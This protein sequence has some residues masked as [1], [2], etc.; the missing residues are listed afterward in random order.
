MASALS[1]CNNILSRAHKEKIEVSPMKLQKLLYY[2][3]VKY[4]K[5][6]GVSPV[7]ERFEVWKYGP[8]VSSVYSVFKPFGSSPI[9]GYYRN[10]KGDV[11]VIDEK[12]NSLIKYCI[13]YVW[14]NFKHTGAID[15]AKRTHKRGSGWYSAFQKH[16]DTISIKEME[17]DITILGT[18]GHSAGY[19]CRR[20]L[21]IR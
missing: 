18:R 11:R 15:L 7:M 3:C 13:D 4:V 10:V 12:N 6:T 1:L 21:P 8:V 20:R 9:K 5:E 2:I 19:C 17:D 14:D 16:H